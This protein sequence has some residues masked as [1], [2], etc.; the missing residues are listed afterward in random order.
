MCLI[1]VVLITLLQF[2]I[3]PL[4]EL[5]IT[6][7]VISYNDFIALYSTDGYI[8]ELLHHYVYIIVFNLF[9]A[10]LI[11]HSLLRY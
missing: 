6:N 9:W 8:K 2:I 7:G 5:Y 4:V 11:L 1:I 10:F 3:D